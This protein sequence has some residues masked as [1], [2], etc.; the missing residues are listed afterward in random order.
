MTATSHPKGSSFGNAINY[1]YE[2]R[3][4]EHKDKKEEL[5]LHSDNIKC[6]E[7]PKI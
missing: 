3:L 5:I 1:I 6:R 2:G 7:M 4:D